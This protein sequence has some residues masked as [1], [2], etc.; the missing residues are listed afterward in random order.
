MGEFGVFASKSW[1]A[2]RASVPLAAGLG[3]LPMLP[4]QV[5]NWAS[6]TLWALFLLAPG[7]FGWNERC[8]TVDQ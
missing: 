7:A 3:N 8:P 5:A 6:A 1:G 4:F 2:L